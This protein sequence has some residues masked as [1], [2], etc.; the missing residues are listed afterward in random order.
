MM[1]SKETVL[2]TGGAGYVGSA[3]VPKLLDEGYKVKV[4]DL[5]IYGE[6][7]FEELKEHPGLE[8]IQGDIRDQE[9]LKRV[10]P[11]CN[12]VI[13]LACIS[14]DPSFEL[15]PEL[16]RSINF[17]AF[18]PL[19]DISKANGVSRFVYASSSSVYGIKEERD[20]SE[21]LPTEPLTD[22]S[23]YKVLC[24]K[25]LLEKSE[26]GFTTLIVRPATVCG[27]APRQRLDVIVNIFANHAFHNRKIKI[28]GGKQL[29]PNIHIQDMV[30]FYIHS[31]E[32][33]A[34]KIDRKVYNVGYQNYPVEEIAL[35]V[36][37]QVGVD[38]SLEVTPSDDNRSYHISSKKI[39]SELGFKPQYS[40]EDAVKSLVDAFKEGKL[41]GSLSESRYYNIKT[42]QEI[43]LH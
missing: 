25:V 33:P 13:H 20:V 24:E 14:N 2:V 23:K 26:D 15:D 43:E 41:K 7:I 39:A 35:M 37:G 30:S 42:M 6:E 36:K 34:S 3:L 22:Y 16:G 11:G 12:S 4:L 21:D 9:L 5:F 19:V 18:G 8:L 32:W 28:F 38:V 10:L 40:V 1:N 29:R 17:D 27:Y 31:L